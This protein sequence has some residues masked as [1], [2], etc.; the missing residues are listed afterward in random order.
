VPAPAARRFFFT[1]HRVAVGFP[2]KQLLREG[3]RGQQKGAAVEDC[4]LLVQGQVAS[5]NA[6]PKN[7]AFNAPARG[8]IGLLAW[9]FRTAL[10]EIRGRGEDRARERPEPLRF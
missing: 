6:R 4:A 10:S 3:F 8:R 1:G 5:T 2:Y 9:A 7:Q